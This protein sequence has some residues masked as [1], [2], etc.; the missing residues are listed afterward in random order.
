MPT[1][2]ELYAELRERLDEQDKRQRELLAELRALR[3]PDEKITPATARRRI[4][5]GLAKSREQREQNAKRKSAE[6]RK[7]GGGA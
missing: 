6:R 1:D 3:R 4:A 7:D 5:S 2:E